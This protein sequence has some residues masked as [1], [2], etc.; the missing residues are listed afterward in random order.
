[1]PGWQGSILRVNLTK[2]KWVVQR[3]DPAVARDFIGGRGLAVK[4]LW[5]EL[6]PGVDPLSP[7]NK[8]IFAAGPLTGLPGPN[9]GKLV[10]AAKS[11]LTG[12]YGD[13]NIGSWAAV[14][15][16]KAGYDAL[17]V[18]GRAERPVYIFIDGDKVEI[19]DAGDYWGLNAWAV[20]E[21]LQ[22]IHGRDA[23]VV[24]I[25][26]AGENLVRFATVVSHKGRSGGRPGM[27]AV[28]GSKN[29]KA[30]VVRGK[31]EIPLADKA[32]YQKLAVEAVKE[33]SSSPSYSFWMRQGTNSTVEWAQEASVLPTYNYTEGQFDEF[34]K[35][36]GAMVEKLET[37]LKACPLCFMACGH[38]IPAESGTVEVDYENIA[39]L[40]SNLG[41]GDLQK[42]AELNRIADTM[43]MDTISLGNVIGFVMEASERGLEDKLGFVVEWGD[44]EAARQLAYDTAYRRGVGDLLAEGVKR[45]SE[46]IGGEDFAIHVK[47]LEVSAYDCHAAPA[48]AL[49]YATSPI[50]A[51]HKD[52]WVISW[53]VK[54]DRM[55]YTRE[56]AA[57]VV[58]LQRI[59]GGWFE[60]FVGCRLPWVEVGLSLDWYPKLFKAATGLDATP[61]YFNEVGDRIYALIRAFWIREY[62]WW[63]REMDTPPKKWFKQ[64][65][66]RGPLKGAHLDYDSYNKLLDYYYEI[67][68][69]DAR[70]VPTQKTLE[71][72][73]LGYVAEQL[74]RFIEL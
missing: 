57:K 32:Q 18:E 51:H 6:P 53:E 24:T 66:S 73:G 3:L 65:L 55:G 49:A 67:R 21:K 22:K 23:A 58:E 20:E 41:I 63:N 31:G 44:Y 4:I 36:G 5:D 35:I 68:G 46:R 74:G 70:G 69:W 38:W 56:K 45:I 52:A 8:L 40:G 17:V 27:G 61:D 19:L 7:H 13:G 1:M 60:T 59:R 71:R 54:T 30:V 37:D 50:G 42:I 47:G 34:N 14:N 28:M 43:G 15:L 33:G 9:F 62:G 29:L 16:R 25:G 11:P 72:L 26:P 64:P 39:M 10:V 12:G 2:R 48:M